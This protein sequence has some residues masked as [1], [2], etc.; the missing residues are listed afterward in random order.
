[1]RLTEFA[2]A[3]RRYDTSAIAQD[4]ELSQEVQGLLLELG[5]LAEMEDPF[6]QRAMAA[7]TRFQRRN[8]CHEP[9]LLGPQTTAKLLEVSELGSRSP[10][11][12]I[13]LEALQNTVLKLRPLESA[14]LEAQEKY[15]LAAGAK[16]ELIY[17]EPLRKHLVLTL[18]QAINGSPVWYAFSEHVKIMGGEEVSAAPAP[19]TDP[20]PL[21]ATATPANQIKLDIPYKSQRDNF[22]NPD[23]SCNVTS[24]AM[25]LEFLAVPRKRTQG[26]FED[27]L[28]EYALDNNLSR[29]SPQDLAKIVRDYSAKD[30]FDVTATINEVK[31]WLAAGNPAVT[32]G[33]FTSFGHIIVFVGYD[34]KGFIVH[35]PYGEWYPSGYDRNALGSQDTKGKFL[36]YSYGL[37]ERTCCTDGQFWV[38][39]I[40]K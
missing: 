31:K 39:F 15:D 10:T 18:S 11:T 32:H 7:L 19:A 37:I 16:I 36:N 23:G 1:M 27:E 5:L 29:H 26:Q 12:I 20:K 21:L 35:D 17:F 3:N 4:P 14:D 33:Y 24:I 2:Q 25:C 40:S 8:D 22:N 28:Y 38:H 9:E 34:E 6:G 30:A 13:T